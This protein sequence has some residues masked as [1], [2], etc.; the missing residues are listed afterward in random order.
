MQWKFYLSIFIALCFLFLPIAQAQQQQ[1][2]KEVTPIDIQFPENQIPD[3]DVTSNIENV[4]DIFSNAA[5][6]F[7]LWDTER[8][9]EL[10]STF[11]TDL[12]ISTLIAE[13]IDLILEGGLDLASIGGLIGGLGGIG[14]AGISLIISGLNALGSAFVDVLLGAGF[15][16]TGILGL[17]SLGGIL[18]LILNVINFAYSTGVGGIAIISLLMVVLSFVGIG[19]LGLVV[20]LVAMGEVILFLLVGILFILNILTAGLLLFVI[21]IFLFV[22][23]IAAGIGFGVIG[24]V[25]LLMKVITLIMNV[26]SIPTNIFT[27]LPSILTLI[28]INLP[29]SILLALWCFIGAFLAF[30]SCSI[31]P[32]RF[33]PG[34]GAGGVVFVLFVIGLIIGIVIGAILGLIGLGIVG[35][36]LG[37]IVGIIVGVIIGIIG[38]V[39]VGGLVWLGIDVIFWVISII[40][41]TLLFVP[42]I[43]PMVI[44]ASFILPSSALYP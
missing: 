16:V 4:Q 13:I 2:E 17:A 30:I 32:L 8:L 40:E 23:M 28:F 44:N 33:I 26:I 7:D 36:I 25:M 35:L 19:V 10:I 37:V 38:G 43:T 39:I 42:G 14:G 31:S 20:L 3:P 15:T 11:I 24:I 22:L 18:S 41:A 5:L 21:G 12:P 27:A 6:G 34:L 1:P 9:G 29:L